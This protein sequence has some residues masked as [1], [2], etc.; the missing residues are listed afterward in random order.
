MDE[1][2]RGIKMGE[3]VSLLTMKLLKNQLTV[4]WENKVK[5]VVTRNGGKN[6]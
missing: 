2:L 6:N 3:S 1:G 5:E 4:S